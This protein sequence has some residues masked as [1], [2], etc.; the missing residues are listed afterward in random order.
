MNSIISIA[1]SGLAAATRRLD[2]SAAN[3]ANADSAGAL[4]GSAAAA[5]GG[6]A[7]FQPLDVTQ[8]PLASGG[9]V[10]TVGNRTPAF[11]PSFSPGSP[12]ANSDGLVA[13]PNVDLVSERLDQLSAIN[14]YTANLRVI[15]AADQ[16]DRETIDSLGRPSHDLSA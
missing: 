5:A 3:V 15:E 9:T 8:Q 4:P 2:V 1:L 11:T 6:P 14:A 16:L 12:F 7:P 10:A 13:A